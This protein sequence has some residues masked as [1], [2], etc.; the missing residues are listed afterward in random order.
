MRRYLYLGVFSAGAATLAVELS[1]SR[2]IGNYFGSSNLVWAAIIGL[3][4]IYLAVGY[5]IGGKWADRSPNYETF[6]AILIW[7][8]L[9]IGVIP[10]ASRP[11]LKFASSAFDQMQTATMI[12]SFLS[13][14][15]LFSIPITLLG[16]ASPFAVRLGLENNETA[17]HTAGKIYAIS[18][19]GSFIGTFLPVLILIPTI[20][21]Y[22][23]FI[24]ISLFLTVVCLVGIWAAESLRKMLMYLWMPILVIILSLIGLGGYDKTAQGIILVEQES[25]YNYIQVQQ[26]NEY[27]ILRLNEGQGIHSISH[28]TQLDFNGYWE[29]VISAPFF[30]RAPVETS[31]IERIA[32][33]G[34][35]GGTSANQAKLAFPEVAIDGYEIDSK[36]IDV[37]FKYFGLADNDINIFI[38]D[39]RWG[40]S[41]NSN[42]YQVINVDAYTP[43]Y[44]PWHLT[45]KEFFA[46]AFDHLSDDGVLVINVA[47]IF[48]ERGLLNSL[49]K[50]VDSVFA[51]TYIVDLPNTF[52]SMIFA[53]KSHTSENNLIDNY[54]VLA[55]DPDTHPL[56]LS[57]LER[58]ILNIQPPPTN[59]YIFTDD[60]APVEW[61]T[62]EMIFNFIISDGIEGLR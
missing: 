47:R 6:F 5:S 16:M 45:T 13:V 19:I 54:L 12:G 8:A 50:T 21:T 41:H 9:F 17:G 51:S 53:T 31:Q 61:I 59:G 14:L 23:T 11:I 57:A 36:I 32:I 60:K 27:N 2:L 18:T 52:N 10:L 39:A 34:L 1:A 3:I 44:I 43:P 29:Q 24:C 42:Q 40:I 35:A 30:N 55:S 25:A 28:P 33:L 38:E 15:I 56:I 37:G 58:A 26:I 7:A 4:L 48:E 49:F 22:R 46:E 62:N 20:G